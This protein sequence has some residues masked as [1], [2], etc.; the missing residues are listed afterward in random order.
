MKVTILDGHPSPDA[1][2]QETLEGLEAA[3]TNAGAVVTRLSLREMDLRP[4]TGCF[5]CWV[6]TPGLCAV[7]DESET[8]CQAQIHADFVLW[9]A[10]L[11]LGFP[12][13]LLKQALDK[14]IPLVHPYFAVVEGEIHH[15]ARYARYPRFGLLLQEEPGLE[16]RLSG[17]GV[18]L[19]ASI[20]AR[21]AI[22][23]KS[24]LEFVARS[25]EPAAEIAAR[26]LHPHDLLPIPPLP[27]PTTGTQVAPPGGLLLLNGSPRGGRGNTPILLREFGA[28]FAQVRPGSVVQRD[29]IRLRETAATVQ[30]VADA[31]AAGHAVVIGF[32]LYTDAMPGSVKQFFEALAPLA[33][34]ATLPPLGF[35]VQCGFPE[36]GHIRYV[37]QYLQHL[38]V[39]L[40]APYLGAMAKGGCEGVHLMPA[41]MNKSLFATLQTLGAGLAHKGLLEPALLRQMAGRDLYP[42]A[43]RPIMR[44]LVRVP[45]INTYWDMQLKKNGAFANR[46]AQPHAQP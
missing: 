17:A 15:R 2:W 37:E 28:G 41:G 36:T 40:G 32:P 16:P 42:A 12:S 29:L 10:P 44:A 45:L 6:K 20:L 3:L 25:T 35:L 9:A 7:A 14:S 43:A 5:G 26:I 1:A 46:F 22:N 23:I 30:A 34:S 24:R 4:C 31:G 33:G 13:A 19:S 18:A 27:P 39:R 21:T 38:A 8:V 11:R